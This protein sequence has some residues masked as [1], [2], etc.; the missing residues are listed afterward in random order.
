MKLIYQE[1]QKDLQ[2]FYSDLFKIRMIR[3]IIISIIFGFIFS[4]K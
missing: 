4:I 2:S 1:T 3:N